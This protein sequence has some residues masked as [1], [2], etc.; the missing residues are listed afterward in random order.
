MNKKIYKMHILQTYL[1]HKLFFEVLVK[2]SVRLHVRHA[3]NGEGGNRRRCPEKAIKNNAK[4]GIFSIILNTVRFYN[5]FL[6]IIVGFK[7]RDIFF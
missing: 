3:T 6:L 4:H 7:P 2:R 1:L 5:Y